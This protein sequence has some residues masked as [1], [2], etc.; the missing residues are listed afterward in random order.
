MY[1]FLSKRNICEVQY[2]G[3]VNSA[4]PAEAGQEPRHRVTPHLEAVQLPGDTKL[5][6]ELIVGAREELA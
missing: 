6:E 5:V 2:F 3:H 1:K 4:S